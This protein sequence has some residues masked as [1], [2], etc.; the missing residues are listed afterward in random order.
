MKRSA[1]GLH[2][3]HFKDIID[4]RNKENCILNNI[5]IPKS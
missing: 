5:T 2:Y 4:D 1:S 3:I